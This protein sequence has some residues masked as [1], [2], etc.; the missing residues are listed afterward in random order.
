MVIE[1]LVL[2]RCIWSVLLA[3]QSGIA[4][5]STRPKEPQNCRMNLFGEVSGHEYLRNSTSPQLENIEMMI[6]MTTN[7]RAKHSNIHIESC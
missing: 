2:H 7:H 1:Q 3:C 4:V 5:G 6:E